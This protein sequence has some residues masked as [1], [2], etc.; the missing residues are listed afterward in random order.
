MKSLVI[1]TTLIVIISVVS[2]S[3]DAQSSCSDK[4]RSCRSSWCHYHWHSRDCPKT[5][6]KCSGAV[7]NCKA[8]VTQCLISNL[9]DPC[10]SLNCMTAVALNVAQCP[11]NSPYR[12]KMGQLSTSLVTSCTTSKLLKALG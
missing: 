4:I 2:R 8:L 6:G 12:S 1:I 9:A 10:A 5:C 3:I 11:R 7:D